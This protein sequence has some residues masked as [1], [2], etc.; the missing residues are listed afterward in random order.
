MK[1][2]LHLIHVDL[3]WIRFVDVHGSHNKLLSLFSMI[4]KD[5]ITTY[6]YKVIINPS[7]YSTSIDMYVFW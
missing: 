1:L 2:E 7:I 4:M 3:L 5:H 6:M